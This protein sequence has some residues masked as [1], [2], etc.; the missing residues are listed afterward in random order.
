[1][2][3]RAKRA[4]A[5]ETYIFR[6]KKEESKYI[7]TLRSMQFSSSVDSS[8]ILGGGGQDPQMYRQK[9]KCICNLYARASEASERL[10]NICI[11]RS[12][13]ASACIYNQC[14]GNKRLTLRRKNMRASGERKIMHILILKLLF[15]SI[16]CWYFRYFVSEIYLFSGLQLH[17]HTLYNQ[18]SMQFLLLLMVWYYNVTD[19]MPTNH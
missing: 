19:S 17:L 3:E 18:S 5:S 11:F 16:F 2:R 10:R 4:S 13:N 6:S 8:L 14:S 7:C 9:N 1:M 15:P 12:Q